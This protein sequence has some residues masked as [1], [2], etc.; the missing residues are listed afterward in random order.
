MTR[1]SIHIIDKSVVKV[2]FEGEITLDNSIN[3]KDELKTYIL[4]NNVMYLVI[5]LEQVSFI[6]SSG[7][8]MLISFF[9][10]INEKK[11]QLVYI[12]IRDYVQKLIELVQLSQVFIIKETE[13]EAIELLRTYYE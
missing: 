4:E 7:L 5:D 2:R 11:G 3:F 9:K 12:G 10:E 13:E 6:D 8:G 1:Y